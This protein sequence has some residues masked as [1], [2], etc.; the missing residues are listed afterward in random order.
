MFLHGPVTPGVAL[1]AAIQIHKG[2]VSVRER[3]VPDGVQTGAFGDGGG[4]DVCWLVV[5]AAFGRLFIFVGDEPRRELGLPAG[6]G[7][8]DGLGC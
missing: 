1:H 2:G 4:D 7:G 3:V 6:E 8:F 5:A